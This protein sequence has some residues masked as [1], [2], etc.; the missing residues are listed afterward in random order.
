MYCSILV[1]KMIP[2]NPDFV[3]G[4]Q[5]ARVGI[6]HNPTKIGS[7][8]LISDD[9]V[10]AVYALKLT[11]IGYSSASFTFDSEIT[12]EVG[13]GSTAVGRVVSYDETTGVLKYW[14][15]KKLKLDLI[16]MELKE[17]QSMVIFNTDLRPI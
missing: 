6:V 4:N 3:V 12:Q 13:L 10:S 16:L 11:G 2:D 7:T 1:L 15:D 8:Q 5:V 9:K 17:Y 14:Q